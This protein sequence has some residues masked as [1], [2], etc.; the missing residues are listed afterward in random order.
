MICGLVDHADAGPEEVSSVL[1]ETCIRI[2]CQV[3]FICL[4]ANVKIVPCFFKQAEIVF[5]I[6]PE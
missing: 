1:Q 3:V 6:Q 2:I 5:N 4:K